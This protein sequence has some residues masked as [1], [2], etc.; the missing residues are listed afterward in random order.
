MTL[1]KF[2]FTCKLTK[3]ISHETRQENRVHVTY[4]D[5]MTSESLV[6]GHGKFQIDFV[7]GF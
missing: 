4:L 2:N 7:A 5:K 1:E 6:A 3:T